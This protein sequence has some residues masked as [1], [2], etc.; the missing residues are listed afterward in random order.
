MNLD[1]LLADVTK[2]PTGTSQ[3]QQHIRLAELLNERHGAGTITVKGVEKWFGRKSISGPWLLKIA[4]LPDK[5]L[6]LAK[7]A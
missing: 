2:L 7:Y 3:R 5:P 6:N 1:Q 4:A